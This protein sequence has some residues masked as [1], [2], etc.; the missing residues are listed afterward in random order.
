MISA[1]IAALELEELSIDS[2]QLGQLALQI[3]DEIF[4]EFLLTE[5]D[6]LRKH[7]GLVVMPMEDYE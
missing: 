5:D 6:Q 2:D 3:A 7:C 1:V 4:E